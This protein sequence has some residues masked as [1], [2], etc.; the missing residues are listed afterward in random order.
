MWPA[1]EQ[2][3]LNYTSEIAD[4][5]VDVYGNWKQQQTIQNNVF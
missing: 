5:Q 1:K 3:L 4:Y 2:S